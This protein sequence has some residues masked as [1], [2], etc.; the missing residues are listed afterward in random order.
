MEDKNRKY[1]DEE[2]VNEKARVVI[3]QYFEF[4]NEKI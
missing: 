2:E 3:L 1:E 4:I